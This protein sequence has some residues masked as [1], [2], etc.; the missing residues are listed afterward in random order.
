M[1]SARDMAR[2]RIVRRDRLLDHVRPRRMNPLVD[3]IAVVAPRPA[4]EGAVL[5]RG[6]VVGH[7]VRPEFVA[8]V[9]HRPERAGLGVEG[10]PVRDC[11]APRRRPAPH[12][13][14]GR[15]AR[16]PRGPSRPR[17][18]ARRRSSSTRPR[19]RG[20]APSGLSARSL[21]QWWLIGP[22]GSGVSTVGAAVI[23]VCAELVGI[24]E[25][26]IGRRDIERAVVPGDAE[27]RV[28]PGQ[29]IAALVDLPVA[30]GV[31]QQA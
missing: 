7:Q 15:P 5:H 29:Q 16:S 14:A 11:A 18:R 31:A 6:H 9:D 21:V 3:M 22:P 17:A 1:P 12:R 30:V 19:R 4:V 25:D 13:S 8:L 27:R 23:S 2:Q 20:I 10:Q 24:G 28:E 26:R